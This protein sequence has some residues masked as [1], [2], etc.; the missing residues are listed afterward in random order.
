MGHSKGQ[1]TLVWDSFGLF[2]YLQAGKGASVI[3]E[4]LGVIL[5][6]Y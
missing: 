1:E 5:L 4:Q 3:I 6:S 2:S